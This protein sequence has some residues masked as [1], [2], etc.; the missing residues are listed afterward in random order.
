MKAFFTTVLVAL[1]ALSSAQ[2]EV[3]EKKFDV[4][5]FSRI[6]IFGSSK[7]IYTQ[8]ETCSVTLRA[9]S[10]KLEDA[11]AYSDGQT[12]TVQFKGNN[13]VNV[14]FFDLIRLLK[15]GIADSEIVFYVTSPDLTAVTL[16]GS[17]DFVCKDKIDTDNISLTLKGSGDIDI[18]NLLCDQL[19]GYVLGSG[20]L[21][22]SRV[23]C[24]TS[25]L[26]L[27]GSGDIKATQYHVKRTDLSVLGSGDISVN[28]NDC[29]E[30]NASVYGSG[31][32]TLSGKIKQLNK[33]VRG[34]GD[35]HY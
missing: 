1:T 19:F 2:A 35:I 14:G 15:H 18:K 33:S 26:E 23:D 30:V 24:L 11:E 13:T 12:L 25:K 34:S 6:E 28:C 7:V 3:T 32:I 5:D 8:G 21:E 17:G 29:V 27:K 4:K 9:E 22:I 31:D 10:S 20:D 16:T